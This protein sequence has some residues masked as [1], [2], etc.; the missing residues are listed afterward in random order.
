MIAEID[1]ARKDHD[2]LGGVVEIRA[3][4]LSSRPRIAHRA[5]AAPRRPA[6]GGRPRHPGHE[7]RRDRRRLGERRAPRLRGARRAGVRR[8]LPPRDQP[9]RRARGRHDERR[10]RRRAHRHEAAADADEAAAHGDARHPRAR[11]RARRALGHDGR[12]ARRRSSAEA[13]VAFEL[14]RAAREKFGG[15]SV[16]DMLA[17]HAAYLARIPWQRPGLHRAHEPPDALV[18]FM[19]A[20][21]STVGACSPRRAACRSPTPTRPSSRRGRTRDPR[22]SSQADGE[23]GPSAPASAAWWRG[24]SPPAEPA[25]WRSAAAPCSTPPTRELLAR[26]G[27]TSCG[28][29]STPTPPGRGWPDERDASTCGATRRASAPLHAER[30]AVYAAAADVAR[31]RR[32]PRRTRSR[33]PRCAT[34]RWCGRRPGAAAG[35][36]R[37]PAR[38]VLVADAAVADRLPAGNCRRIARGRGR[39]GGQ[40]RR[41]PLDA[42]WQALADAELERRDVVVAVGGGTVTDAAGFAA[43]TFRRGIAWIAVPTTLVGQVDAAIGGKTAINVAAKND[44]GA[45]H[46]PERVVAR[47]ASCWRRCRRASG[48]PGSPRS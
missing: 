14:A 15:D 1:A 8:R 5:A 28:S 42:L 10:D 2:T 7:G 34:R 32:R 46:L 47:P 12:R 16:G 18:G 24:S 19:G 13:V 48:R 33:P 3:F 45:F 40:D 26:D 20:G 25:W 27:R 44:V 23:P 35:A 11:D 6:R 17:A 29:T 41:A 39:G 43:A 38:A 9:R 22:R 36:R 37:R 4:R 21:K 31:R 30:R